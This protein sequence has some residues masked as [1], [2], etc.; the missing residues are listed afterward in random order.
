MIDRLYADVYPEDVSGMV[1]VDATHED[2]AFGDQPFR[3]LFT[4]KPIPA[5][6]TMKSNPPVAL[7]ADEQKRFEEWKAGKLQE[8]RTPPAYP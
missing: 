8:S 7:T 4:G 3:E 6:Q 5:V 2:I 1:L